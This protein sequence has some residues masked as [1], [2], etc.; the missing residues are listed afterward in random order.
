[1]RNKSEQKGRGAGKKSDIAARADLIRMQL[2]DGTTDYDR[3]RL[4]TPFSPRATGQTA[5]CTVPRLRVFTGKSSFALIG[6]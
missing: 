6:D 2:A 1:L 5:A 3:Q 4:R